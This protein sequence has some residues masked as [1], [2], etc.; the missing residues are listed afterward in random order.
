ME[1]GH[2]DPD[3]ATLTLS[4][5]KPS[6]SGRASDNYQKIAA[7]AVLELCPRCKYLHM[8]I[9]LLFRVVYL[10]FPQVVHFL[11]YRWSKVTV[12]ASKSRYSAGEV[13]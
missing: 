9:A 11:Q 12:D 10:F 13:L 6:F 4:P 7:H 5:L 8:R 1:T 3:T 2:D